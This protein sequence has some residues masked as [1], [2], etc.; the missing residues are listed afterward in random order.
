MYCELN[1]KL[2]D[3]LTFAVKVHKEIP[4]LNEL[5]ARLK[6]SEVITESELL[7]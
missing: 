2:G 4:P 6:E 1:V 7:K 3:L 5:Q